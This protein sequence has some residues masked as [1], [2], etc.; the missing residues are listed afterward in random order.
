MGITYVRESGLGLRVYADAEYA[1][2][3]TYRRSVSGIAI[4]LGG[5]VLSHV[6]KT[7]HVVL[8]STSK[9]E[10]TVAGDGVE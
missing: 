10:Y 7:Q 1:D 8:L 4:T 9:A 2:K 6:S 3:A 5:A